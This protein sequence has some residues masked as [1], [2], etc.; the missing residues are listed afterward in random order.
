MCID[1]TMCYHEAVEDSE[2]EIH[3]FLHCQEFIREFNNLS[4]RTMKV[5]NNITWSA[6]QILSRLCM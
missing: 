3:Q 1:N 5:I 2:V 6:F 4:H